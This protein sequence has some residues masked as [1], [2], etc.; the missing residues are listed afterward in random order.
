MK[1]KFTFLLLAFVMF[2]DLTNADIKPTRNSNNPDVNLSLPQ[3]VSRSYFNNETDAI[4]AAW[5]TLAVSPKPQSRSFCV[6]ARPGG[7]EYIYHFGGGA[8]ATLKTIARYDIAANTWS[9][10][11]QVLNLDVSSGAAINN[12]DSVIYIFGGNSGTNPGSTQKFNIGTG[13]TT[14]LAVMPNRITDAAVVKYH[15]SL[16]YVIGGGTGLFGAGYVNNVDVYNIKT[17]TY[18]AATAYPIAAGMMGFGIDGNKIICAAG[19]DG[20]TGTP[21]AYKGVIDPSNHLIIVWTAIPNYPLG[22]VTRSASYFVSKGSEKGVMFTGGAINGATVTNRTYLFNT[23]CEVWDSTVANSEARSNFKAAGR[24]DSVAW[25]VAGFNGTAGVGTTERITFSSIS[26]ALL[27]NDVASLSINS[28]PSTVNLPSPPIVPQATVKNVGTA[29]QTFNVTMTISPAGYSSTKTVTALT[30]NSTSNVNFDPYTPAIGSNTVTVYTQ[31]ASDQNKGNDTVRQSL[32]VSN[33]NYGTGG[34]YSFA[35]SITGTGAPSNPEFCWKD[36]TG[37]TSLV[38]NSVNSLPGIFA[39]SLD[40]GHWKVGNALGGKKIRFGG[41]SYDSF[42]VATNGTI[43]FAFNSLLNSFSPTTTSTNRPAMYPLWMDMNLTANA[44][45]PVNRLSYRVVDGFQLVITYDRIPEFSPVGTDDYVSFQVVID[46]VDASYTSNS[47]LMAQYA[48]TTG[49]RTGAGFLGFYNANTLNNHVVGLQTTGGTTNLY[50]RAQ[51]TGSP[52]NPSGPL[53]G[54]APIAVQFGP[55]ATRLNHRC[56]T[57]SMSITA[58]FEGPF[59]SATNFNDPVTIHLRSNTP[60]YEIV[61]G[62]TKVLSPTGTALFD[63]GKVSP[64]GS[65]YIV[66]RSRFGIETWSANPVTLPTASYNFTSGVG[67]AFGSNMRLISGT[68]TIYVGDV[69]QD[70]IIDGTDGAA[71]DNDSFIFAPGFGNTDLNWDGTVDG[72]DALYTDNNGLNFIGV[73]RP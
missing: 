52:A 2:A 39:G 49:G 19:W 73:V 37:S 9:L 25:V 68:A 14:T 47:R 8:G 41:V 35:N 17:N 54:A 32:T 63:F 29:T 44:S 4:S 12:G 22:G 45:Y 72:S 59:L 40:D 66:V 6:Y 18:A 57:S 30:S 58:R 53:Y 36:T 65:Y 10:L 28:P 48:D 64:S 1:S 20:V 62:D 51:V 69:N 24:G 46:L 31:L 26:C 34:A 60:P 23:I 71:V 61:D 70:G 42:F 5:T 21:N 11:A 43:G 67:Q 13:I 27:T 15:D 38:V 16:I 7:T 56:G 3:S 50:Y 33:P 55:D